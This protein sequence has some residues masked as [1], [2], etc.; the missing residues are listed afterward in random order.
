MNKWRWKVFSITTILALALALCPTAA[1]NA[2]PGDD[3]IITGIIDMAQPPNNPGAG[4]YVEAYPEGG[5]D[6]CWGPTT[7]DGVSGHYD[8][9]MTNC[10]GTKK[11]TVV[12]NGSG[13]TFNTVTVL[14]VDFVVTG[15]NLTAVA[16]PPGGSGFIGPRL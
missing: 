12:A 16:Q 3:D 5:G 1:V 2:A 6:S 14:A 15:P 13:Y 4:F 10:D 11:Y 9:E 8:Y 7:W